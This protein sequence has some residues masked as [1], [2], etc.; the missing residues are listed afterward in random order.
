MVWILHLFSLPRF[1]Y[2]DTDV[3]WL[4]PGGTSGGVKIHTIAVIIGYLN[5]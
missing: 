3:Y 2:H 4:N 1:F 5:D